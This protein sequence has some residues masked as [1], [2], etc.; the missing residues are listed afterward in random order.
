M[1]I[2][3]QNE[4]YPDVA[5]GG[6]GAI[7]TY[8][9]T[10]SMQRLGHKVVILARGEREASPYWENVKGTT[11]QR[12]APPNLPEK[13]WP[14]WPLLEPY[15]ARASLQAV[16]NDYDAFVGVDF[17]F[18]LNV[19]KFFPTRPLIYRVEGNERS[20]QAAVN[21]LG[22]GDGSEH[23]R[24]SLWE[25][26]LTA[27]NDL[28]ER[29]VWRTC[30]AIV[31]KSQFMKRELHK[32]YGVATDNVFVIPNGVDY[33]RYASAKCTPQVLEHLENPAGEKVVIVFCG[34][35]VRMKNVSFLLRA[36]A[37]MNSRN[38]CLL[39]LVGD[40][41]ERPALESEADQ[42]GI[43]GSVKFLGYTERAEEYLAGADIFVLPSAYEP[44]GNAL[45]EAMAAGLPCVALKP[46]M[47]KIRTASDE[48]LQNGVTGYL[49]SD[50]YQELSE[51]LDNLVANAELRKRLGVAAQS[52][53][54]EEYS[55]ES[56]ART[57]LLLAEQLTEKLES[58]EGKGSAYAA[59]G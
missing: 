17:S 45:V 29:R 21:A 28:M 41:D 1:R 33:E 6:G 7:N 8:Y 40:G 27:E 23:R 9:I 37:R 35:L 22:N 30:D 15:Y 53:C 2:L 48:I 13:L 25:R 4:H 54:R 46:D 14:L 12:L 10:T 3:W 55:W 50:R 49:V 57:Y 11:V 34:R 42:L 43:R 47:D 26:C 31:V 44:F 38:D 52:R 36:F 32:W 5:K 18:A 58:T 39:A 19:R 59:R 51:T 20:H 56:C 16:C 24:Q